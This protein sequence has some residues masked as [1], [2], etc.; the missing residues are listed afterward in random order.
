[1]G[2]PVTSFISQLPNSSINIDMFSRFKQMLARH[3]NLPLLHVYY[4]MNSNS[5]TDLLAGL[6]SEECYEKNIFADSNCLFG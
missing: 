2:I 5:F 3:S 1:M 4:V 6:V